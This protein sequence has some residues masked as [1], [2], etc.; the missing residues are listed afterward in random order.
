MNNIMRRSKRSSIQSSSNRK[1][2]VALF[3]GG[4]SNEADVSVISA[5]NIVKNFDYK[6]YDL[7]L[8]Y[9]HSDGSFFL[10]R[11][12][13]ERRNK[14][15]KRIEPS[16]FTDIMDVALL[17]THGKYGED[18][19]LQAILEAHGIPYTGCGVLAS[20]LCMDKAANKLLMQGHGIP[21]TNFFTLD[22]RLMS[23]KERAAILS[24]AVRDLNFP[25]F[26]KPANSG[27]SVGISRV[28]A[29][30]QMHTALREARRHDDRIIIEQGLVAPREIEVGVLG[31]DRL[32]VSRP[33]EIVAAK[34]FYDFEDKYKLGKSR[35]LVPADLSTSLQKQIRTMAERIYR[36]CGCRGFARVDFFLHHGKI[37]F[38]EINTLPGFTDISMFPMLMRSSGI[39]YT[40][41]I[42]RIIEL[43]LT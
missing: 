10:V 31:N 14:S 39:E 29:K 34:A 28:T 1:K 43:A 23:V 36:L 15:A 35:Q 22:Y 12:V 32:V 8:V 7:N 40:R 2:R 19:V 5:R 3:F 37:Y 33:G 4:M 18:G 27:S 20:A 11:S 21:Q 25:L 38:N 41:L 26:V 42:G 9:W 24:Q 13:D 16:A 6:K 17:I 30:G